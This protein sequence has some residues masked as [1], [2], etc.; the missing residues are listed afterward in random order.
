[1]ERDI[2]NGGS[3]SSYYNYNESIFL[4]ENKMKRLIII[5]GLIILSSC[6][7]AQRGKLYSLGENAKVECW[8]GGTLI[9]SGISTGKVSSE[10]SSDGYHF[11]DKATGKYMEVSGNCVI[12]YDPDKEKD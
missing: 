7:Q 5:I 8:S 12:T 3:G 11:Y 9:Y 2:S 4:K 6:T 10:E 1:M